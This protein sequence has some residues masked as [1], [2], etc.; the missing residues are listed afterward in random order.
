MCSSIL[1]LTSVLSGDGLSVQLY[2]RERPGILCIEGWVGHRTG[3]D[4]WGKSTLLLEFDPGTVHSL[5]QLRYSGPHLFSFL[6]DIFQSNKM[7]CI[8]KRK[9]STSICTLCSGQSVNTHGIRQ[10]IRANG[11]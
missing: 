4:G 1:S 8:F 6:Y 7:K 3:L 10:E 5:Y 11:K 2:P 9:Y